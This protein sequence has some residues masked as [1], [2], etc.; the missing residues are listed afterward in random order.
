MLITSTAYAILSLYSPL[1]GALIL[2]PKIQSQA[3]TLPLNLI[4]DL[5]QI[6]DSLCTTLVVKT[7]ILIVSPRSKD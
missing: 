3:V 4:H 2:M 7:G 5:W 6:I 1:L